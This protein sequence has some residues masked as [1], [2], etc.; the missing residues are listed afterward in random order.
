MDNRLKFHTHASS[1]TVKTSKQSSPH[2]MILLY[3]S[4]RVTRMISRVKD[5]P[6][7]ER[8]KAL[9]LP[10]LPYRRKRNDMMTCYKV[11]MNIM[12][13]IKVGILWKKHVTKTSFNN[14]FSS[15]FG[16]EGLKKLFWAK[17]KGQLPRFGPK[18][19]FSQ[20]LLRR[21]S[22]LTSYSHEVFIW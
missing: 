2:W 16:T 13:L 12:K 1:S 14:L 9:S 5:L 20:N 19:P 21:I 8:L 22:Q 6:Y 10:S 3:P 17:K 15:S 11:M 7:T 18:S 4:K